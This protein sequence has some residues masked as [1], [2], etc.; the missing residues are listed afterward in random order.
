[1]DLS[2][3]SISS[4]NPALPVLFFDFGE[5]LRCQKKDWPVYFH[6]PT[7]TRIYSEDVPCNYLHVNIL[8]ESC[9]PQI[10]P[11]PQISKDHHPRE[12]MQCGYL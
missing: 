3:I 10:L 8:E 11:Q 4:R 2:G 12:G 5:L 1:M 7:A 9:Y 6:L